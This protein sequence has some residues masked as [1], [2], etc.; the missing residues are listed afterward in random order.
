[1]TLTPEQLA[2]QVKVKAPTGLRITVTMESYSQEGMAWAMAQAFRFATEH[3]MGVTV[4]HKDDPTTRAS[5]RTTK[6]RK[7]KP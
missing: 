4:S 6:L 5:F 7:R 3:W 1:M 2:P